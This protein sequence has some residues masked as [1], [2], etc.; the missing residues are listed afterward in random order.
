[1]N[2]KT[3]YL[4]NE[5]ARKA[6]RK[7]TLKR[8]MSSNIPDEVK[9]IDAVK[10]IRDDRKSRLDELLDRINENNIHEE[11]SIGEPVGAEIIE[12]DYE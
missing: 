10:L 4:Q 9:A 7:R 2:K 11:I 8:I 3:N 1:M 5:K 12:D 6:R